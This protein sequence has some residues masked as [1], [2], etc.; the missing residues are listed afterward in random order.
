MTHLPE[1]RISPTSLLFVKLAKLLRPKLITTPQDLMQRFS[2]PET[3]ATS[4][5]EKL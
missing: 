5:K 3:S 2:K 1:R 4:N